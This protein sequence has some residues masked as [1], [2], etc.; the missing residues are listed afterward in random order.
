MLLRPGLQGVLGAEP[1]GPPGVCRHRAASAGAAE[2][3]MRRSPAFKH[4]PDIGALI[5]IQFQ[6]C[7]V[8]VQFT[9][10]ITSF[11]KRST[12]HEDIRGREDCSAFRH[13]IRGRPV[14]SRHQVPLC[15]RPLFSAVLCNISIWSSKFVSL[16]AKCA[17]CVGWQGC[18]RKVNRGRQTVTGTLLLRQV[19]VAAQGAAL[20]TITPISVTLPPSSRW[21][22]LAPLLA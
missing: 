1:P 12:I 14:S 2:R 7:F 8:C 3:Q 5:P 15:H 18:F 20:R 13:R 19:C 17:T 9:T 21:E 6:Q 4:S 22:A 16:T 10:I 11:L